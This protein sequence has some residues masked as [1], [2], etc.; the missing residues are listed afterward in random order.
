MESL[1]KAH[2][3][4]VS[5]ALRV[6]LAKLINQKLVLIEVNKLHYEGRGVAR[7][8]DSLTEKFLYARDVEVREAVKLLIA[9]TMLVG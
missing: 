4:E 6:A 1:Q 3:S 9:E 8:R 7:L 2:L 5:L